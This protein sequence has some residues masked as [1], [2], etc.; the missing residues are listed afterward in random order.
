MTQLVHEHSGHGD[1]D[2]E[3]AWAQQ[4]GLSLAKTDLNTATAEC[5][6]S[7]PQKQTLS[8]TYDTVPCLIS[9]IVHIK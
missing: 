7:Q 3:Y 6:I 2:G 5:L 8:P 9:Q 1:K 4:Q